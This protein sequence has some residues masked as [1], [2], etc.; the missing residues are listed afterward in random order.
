M[1]ATD[2]PRVVVIGSA[3]MDL[4]ATVPRLPGR[5]ETIAGATF[6]QAPGGKGA[7]QAVAAARLGAEVRFIGC[8]GD[9]D[10]GR[11][12][13]RSLREAGVNAAGVKVSGR[14]RTGVALIAVERGGQNQIVVATGANA[15][16]SPEDVAAAESVIASA[17][18]VLLQLEVPMATVAAAVALA[19]RHGV[20]CVLNPAPAPSA[21][22]P[23]ELRA[24]DVICPNEFEA[25]ALTGVVADSLDGA[26]EQVR[27]LLADGPS[28]AVVTLGV[29]G[30][31][32]GERGGEMWHTP[33][34]P[35]EA[36]DATAAGDAFVA[37]LTVALCEGRG[38]REAV[39]FAASAGALATTRPGAQP[40]LP[41]REEVECLMQ[42]AAGARRAAG[43]EERT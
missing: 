8:V 22:P 28:L 3:N 24:V 13:M 9:D 21:P 1:I 31:M 37:A 29:R 12:L 11:E 26:R 5:G 19:R 40:S 17:Q 7:N 27:H 23:R 32:A 4:I 41:S 42:T 20:R 38:A 33:A 35:V 14:A 43:T 30:A 39:A 10:Y 25:A 18:A 2:R 34:F 16:L 6:S 36:V 15:E